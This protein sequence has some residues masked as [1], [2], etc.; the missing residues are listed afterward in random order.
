MK[1]LDLRI[2]EN[3]FSTGLSVRNGGFLAEAA[4]VCL[5]NHSHPSEVHFPVEGNMREN[6]QLCRLVI[7]E[8]VINSYADIDEAAQFGAM[9]IAVML[10][11]DQKGWK[12][13]RSWKGTGFDYWVGEQ[14]DD[15]PFQ[16]FLRLEVSGDFR[17]S[18]ADLKNRLKRKLNQ[19]TRSDSLNL[20]A[21]AII[22]EFSNPT[23]LTGSR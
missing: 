16:N 6:Y 2:L 13:K 14:N 22:V 11:Y 15:Y 8:L 19:T 9:G 5:Y 3:G 17:G 12:V 7:D 21:C 23:S 18:N 10:M 20:S 1:K 4:S